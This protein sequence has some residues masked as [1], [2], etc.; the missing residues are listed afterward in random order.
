[1]GCSSKKTND[2]LESNSKINFF[3]NQADLIFDNILEDRKAFSSY[4]ADDLSYRVQLKNFN[5]D[6][7]LVEKKNIMIESGW[8]FLKKYNQSYIYCHGDDQLEIIVPRAI[9]MNDKL[10]NGSIG[11]QL[12]D[13]WNIMFA[14]PKNST[15][16][17]CNK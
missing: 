17:E 16:F 7:F 3:T 13:Q 5:Y 4:S 1:M 11:M 6:I 10:V 8:L 14:H 2:V 15:W 9:A 12:E